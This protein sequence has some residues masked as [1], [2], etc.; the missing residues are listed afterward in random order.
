MVF[1]DQLDD[2]LHVFDIEGI[3]LV[4][5]AEFG[6][7]ELYFCSFLFVEPSVNGFEVGVPQDVAIL[8]LLGVYCSEQ[9]F[10]GDA[11]RSRN[12]F[13]YESGD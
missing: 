5:H 9:F 7:D 8:F 12:M 4:D 11:L 10:D 2:G 6:V 3:V 1:K 13:Q